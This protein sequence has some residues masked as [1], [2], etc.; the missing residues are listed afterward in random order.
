[1]SQVTSL[2]TIIQLTSKIE[3]IQTKN[4]IFDA[5]L[6]TALYNLC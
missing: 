6:M 5:Y 2:L 1:M 3:Q 4:S